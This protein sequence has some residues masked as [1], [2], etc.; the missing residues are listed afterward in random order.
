MSTMNDVRNKNKNVYVSIFNYSIGNIF[1][2][3]SFSRYLYGGEDLK[4]IFLENCAPGYLKIYS[5]KFKF[6]SKGDP[7]PIVQEYEKR[8]GKNG[9]P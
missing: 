3:Y 5:L 4:K 1:K 8:G 9:G 6:E 2:K 7:E